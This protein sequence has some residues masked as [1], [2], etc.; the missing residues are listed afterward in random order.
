MGDSTR[1]LCSALGAS[2]GCSISR[3][4]VTTVM[5]SSGDPGHPSVRTTTSGPSPDTDVN[6]KK[7]LGLWDGV[8][9]IVGTMIG[10]GI[11]VSPKTVV[12]YT[13]SVGMSLVVWVATGFMSMVGALCYAELG[14][15]IPRSGCSYTYILEAF[16]PVPAFLSMWVNVFISKTCSRAIVCITFANYLLQAFLPECSSLPYYAVKFL[17]AAML[18]LLGYIN[19]IGVKLGSRLQDILAITKVLGLIIIIIAGVYHL[20]RGNV[21][22]FLDPMEGTIWDVSS[23]ATAFYSTLFTYSGWSSLN[24]VTGELKEPHKNLPRAI[25]ISMVIV[26]M[27]YTLTN[28][29]YYAVLTPAE[30]LSSNAVAVTFGNRM[31]GVLSWIIAFFVACSTAGNTNSGLFTLPRMIHTAAL[32]GQLPHFLSF[33]HVRYYTPITAVIATTTLPLLVLA[34][35]DIGKLLTYT[36]F[37]NNFIGL[38]GVLSLLWLRYKEP[39]RP[40]PFK[41]WLGFP[42]LYLA[43]CVFVMVFP[44][45]TRP[46]EIAVAFALAVVSLVV[47][48]FTIHL[49]YKPRLLSLIMDKVTY[50]SQVLLHCT[51]EEKCQ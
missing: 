20:A 32:E 3:Q 17:G 6:L 7:V 8:G 11:F 40:R 15:T 13:G 5:D 24:Y 44:V 51:P 46:L 36:S 43:L 37:I 9:F 27:V 31:L 18:C 41:L 23:F 22:H 42:L 29:A 26:T 16:G 21:S 39:D 10:S 38:L 12:Q 4:N 49:H 30:I 47:Y 48:F 19:C 34:I 45:V 2:S 14:T 1:K 50:V 28:I 33:V 25:V 35:D